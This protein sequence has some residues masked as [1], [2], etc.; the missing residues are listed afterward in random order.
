MHIFDTERRV[1]FPLTDMAPA[2]ARHW[3]AEQSGSWVDVSD[4]VVLLLSEL[5]ANSVLH[6][7]L[8]DPAEVEISVRR[9]P[10][11]LHVEV[12]DQGVGIHGSVLPRP[13]HYGLVFAE[14]VADR[15]GYTN[16]P[17]RVWFE[18]DGDER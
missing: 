4:R 13:D 1:S 17:T 7:G 9:V 15:W 2:S 14:R 10:G 12:I 11:G 18:I 8:R 6:S 5:V 16:H 3:F